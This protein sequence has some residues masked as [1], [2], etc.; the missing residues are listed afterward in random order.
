MD[1]ASRAGSPY[2]EWERRESRRVFAIAFA[3]CLLGAALDF[4]LP[5]RWRLLPQLAGPPRG[6]VDKV[7]DQAS[8]VTAFA[9]I[10]TT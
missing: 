8:A 10:G 1:L 3:I 7:K 2:V 4:F 9:L 6:F 5:P